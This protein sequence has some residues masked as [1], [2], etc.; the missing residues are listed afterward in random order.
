[1]LW[2]PADNWEARVIVAGERARDGD[3]ALN[4]LEALRRNPFRAARDFEGSN[5]RDIV[6]S[7]VLA[8]RE[9]QRFAFSSTTGFVRWTTRGVTDLDYT[10][11][12]LITRDNAE[13]DAQFTQEIRLAWLHARAFQRGQLYERGRVAQ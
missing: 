5:E 6:S 1:V 10:P 7:T 11:L 12:S 4:D 13:D 8:R 3:L 9:G 2:T